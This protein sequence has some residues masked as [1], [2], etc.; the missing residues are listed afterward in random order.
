MATSHIFTITDPNK[1]TTEYT[2]D[3]SSAVPATILDATLLTT[4]RYKYCSLRPGNYLCQD[5][6]MQ[7]P[8]TFI[9]TVN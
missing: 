2:Y 9:H 6:A 7:S 5:G 8:T 3:V 4:D 1:S